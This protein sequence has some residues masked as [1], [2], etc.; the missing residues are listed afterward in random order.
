MELTVQFG[1]DQRRLELP[2]ADGSAAAAAGPTCAD[3]ATALASE[4]GVAP[5]TIKLLVPGG[6]GLLRL[7][8]Q[9]AAPLE[10]AGIRPGARLKMMAS[11][12]AAVEAVRRQ[13]DDA[14]TR[15]F[16]GELRRELQRSGAA[17]AG[18]RLPSG[19]YTFQRY[20]AWQ[21]PG[22]AP[23]PTEALKLL[24]RLAADPGIV[25]VMSEHKWTVG[26]LSEMPPEGKV[27][28]SPV[29]ILGVNINRGQEISLRLRTDDLKGFRR[30]DRIRETLMHELAHMVWGEHDDNF[31]Q[32][33]SQ[34]RRECD[35]HDW[36]GAAARSLAGPAFEG[37]LQYDLPPERQT[38]M[39]QTAVSSGQTLR[40]LAGG[41]AA[42]APADAK[43]AAAE[44]ALR[45]SGVAPSAAVVESSKS[46]VFSRGDLVLYTQRDGTQEQAK[47]VAVDLSVQPPSYGIELPG[48]SYRETEGGR[49]QALPEQPPAVEGL[50][51][52]DAATEAKEDAA[53]QLEQ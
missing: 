8:E 29:C 20:E 33:N 30:Y 41:Q 5:H 2:V 22:L 4:F 35:A 32:L 44:A 16:E 1:K 6:K 18:P 11:A 46:K 24:H 14:L 47:V 28:V 17:T 9:G 50:G 19:P 10:Q 36:R 3:L 21:R 51:H 49:L 25:G 13:R 39:Q 43:V 26:L 52:R 12:A 31:K 34:L 48:G 53:R 27:G 42:V 23:P 15:G 40:Q 37:G 38:V 45:R 7:E